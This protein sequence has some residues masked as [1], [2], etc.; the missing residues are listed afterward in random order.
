MPCRWSSR[1]PPCWPGMALTI[2]SPYWEPDL[3]AEVYDPVLHGKNF[4]NGR[5]DQV[6]ELAVARDDGCHPLRTGSD[7][8]DLD[9]EAVA[10]FCATDGDWAG[11]RVHLREVDVG[12]Q[13]VLG[14]DLA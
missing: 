9:H 14:L 6:Y 13:V 8:H 3:V 12:D 5:F 10:G 7:I 4:G 2:S 11:G 1:L